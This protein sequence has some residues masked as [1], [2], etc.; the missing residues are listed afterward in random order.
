[1][2]S[3]ILSAIRKNII[4]ATLTMNT[5]Q[6]GSY[7][8]EALKEYEET[9]YVNEYMPADIRVVTS[10]NIDEYI[11]EKEEETAYEPAV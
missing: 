2:N 8:I 11:S 6:M 7:C 9:G 10:D 1:E 4:Y 5:D 3:T